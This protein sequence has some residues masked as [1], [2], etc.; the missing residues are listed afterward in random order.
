M[1][2]LAAGKA[3]QNASP[4]IVNKEKT[5]VIVAS[6][7]GAARTTF[8]FLDSYIEKGDSL[9]SPT[10]FSNSV[11]NAA[12]AHI[13]IGY[14][15]QG[16]SLTVSQF[17]MSFISA[18]LSAGI[19][20]KEG[21]VDSVLIGSCD[22]YC[23]VLG[24]C[25]RGLCSKKQKAYSFSE[26]STFFLISAQKDDDS[27]HGWFSDLTMGNYHKDKINIPEKSHLILSPCSSDTNLDDFF[28]NSNL[29]SKEQ[30]SVRN[31]CLSPTDN[32]IDAAYAAKAPQKICHIKLGQNGEYGQFIHTPTPK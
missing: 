16:P 6:G 25:I 23:N 10:H 17:D 13:S 31:H 8:A 20:L 7:F 29:S 2:M 14:G 3:I 9:A 27:N 12:A 11:H 19:W 18:L 30:M 24:Y 21:K 4:S 1:A 5:G 15:I 32:A 22:E 26:G 28:Q